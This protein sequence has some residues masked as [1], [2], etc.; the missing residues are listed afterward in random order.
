M[1]W[2]GRKPKLAPKDLANG[3]TVVFQERLTDPEQVRAVVKSSEGSIC[4][5]GPIVP[6][7]RHRATRRSVVRLFQEQQR[8]GALKKEIATYSQR[9]WVERSWGKQYQ[10]RTTGAGCSGFWQLI[11]CL[12]AL[13]GV[14][15][16]L[17]LI[18]AVVIWAWRVVFG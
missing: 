16:W 3:F 17:L 2:I 14:A 4:C 9:S 7:A 15:F 10:S 5:R 12:G 1:N 6:R 8:E 11:G 13:A 18:A